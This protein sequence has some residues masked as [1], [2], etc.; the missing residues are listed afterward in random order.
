MLLWKQ[1][2]CWSAAKKEPPLKKCA[3]KSSQPMNNG[4]RYG[5]APFWKWFGSWKPHWIQAAQKQKWILGPKRSSSHRLG[6]WNELFGAE[7]MCS[8]LR[9][10]G[11][12]SACA[13]LGCNRWSEKDGGI[14][15]ASN[16]CAMCVIILRRFFFH[17]MRNSVLLRC[18][19]YNRWQQVYRGF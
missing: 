2:Q 16:G 3:N 19:C 4:W 17:L 8:I 1:N 12:V 7:I 18:R 10:A 14:S 13:L 15:R 6:M 11:P 5:C 9:W